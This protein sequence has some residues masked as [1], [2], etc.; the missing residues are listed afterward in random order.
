MTLKEKYLTESNIRAVTSSLLGRISQLTDLHL[1][2]ELSG[3]SALLIIDMQD[4]FL[5]SES[6]AFV[7]SSGVIVPFIIRLAEAYQKSG[8]LV[9]FT[10]HINTISNAGK[11]KTW[12][13]DILTR[14]HPFQEISNSFRTIERLVIEKSQYDA[15]LGT[16]LHEILKQSKVKSIS[17][18]GVMTNLCCEATARSAFALGYEVIVPVDNTAAYNYQFHFSSLLNLAHGFAYLPESDELI[19]KLH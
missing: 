7:P 9:I 3:K 12:W 1:L 11:M 8:N 5:D 4:Y 17:I 2:P 18:T 19:K 15:F 16:D 10:K 13:R 14:D 6:H